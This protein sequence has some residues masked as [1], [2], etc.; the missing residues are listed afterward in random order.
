VAKSKR[1]IYLLVLKILWLPALISS[2]YFFVNYLFAGYGYSPSQPIYFSHKVHSGD[3]KLKCLLCHVEAEKT[4]FSALPS[5]Y[6]CM[7]CHT[8]LKT[9]TERMKHLITSY[10][11]KTPLKWN[12]IYRLPEHSHFRH[13]THINASIDCASCHGEI[14]KMETVYKTTNMSMQWCLNCHRDPQKYIIPIREIS[15][16]FV[17]P[18]INSIALNGKVKLANSE[19]Y[20][21][22]N[23]GMYY[24]GEPQNNNSMLFSKLPGRGPETCSACHY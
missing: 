3:Y 9:E 15:G 24:T 4:A 1:N 17:Y 18:D 2:Y 8:A 20:V 14:E 12:R 13:N 22:P 6:S 11:S 21:M 10:D 19:A 16:I 5:T 23:Y 7:V